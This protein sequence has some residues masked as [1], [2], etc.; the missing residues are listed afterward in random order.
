[1]K[2]RRIN[3][4]KYVALDEH[5]LKLGSCSVVRRELERIFPENPVQYVI[6]V[7]CN[8]ECRDLLY[9]AAVTRAR[10]IAAREKGPCRIFADLDVKDMQG[11]E[12]IHA[13]G[14]GG[15]DGLCRMTRRVTDERI[16]LPV[17]VH[18]TIVRDFLENEEERKKCLKRYNEC[19]GEEYDMDWLKKLSRKRDFARILMVSPSELCGELMVW[20]QGYTGIIGILQVARAWRRRGVGSYLVEDARK[21]FASI[22]LNDIYFDI[23]LSSPGCLPLAKK[24]GFRKDEMLRVYPKLEV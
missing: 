4:N 7:S 1:M 15:S 6:S 12:V 17:P 18:C 20:S 21:Y 3:E 14:F 10:L 13:L 23:W 16:T 8:D 9:G 24:C 5:D 11:L 19:F 2:I 22:G